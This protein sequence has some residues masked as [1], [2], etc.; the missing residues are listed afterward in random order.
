MIPLANTK[1]VKKSDSPRVYL[2]KLKKRAI[3]IKKK[4]RFKISVSI[5]Q[6][7]NTLNWN[8]RNLTNNLDWKVCFIYF[9]CELKKRVHFTLLGCWLLK[10]REE[11]D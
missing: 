8:N 6:V 1:I 10:A 9:I 5:R 3:A 4:I 7:A 2:K 11:A